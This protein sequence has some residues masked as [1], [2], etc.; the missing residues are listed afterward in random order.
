M[1]YL[2]TV[3]IPQ[4]KFLPKQYVYALPSKRDHNLQSIWKIGHTESDFFE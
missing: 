3:L 1:N 2:L 4:T